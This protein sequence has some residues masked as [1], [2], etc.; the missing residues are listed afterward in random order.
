MGEFNRGKKFGGWKGG[1]KFG[2]RQFGGNRGGNRRFS[3]GRDGGRT[4]M[5]RAVCSNCGINCEVPFRP[6]GDKPVFCN[7]CFKKMGNRGDDSQRNFRDGRNREFGERKSGAFFD[8]K[9]PYQSGGRN[10]S[11]NYKAQFEILNSKLDKILKALTPAVSAQINKDEEP[12]TKKFDKPLKKEVDT[13]SLRK[14][15]TETMDKKHTAKENAAGKKAA[16]KK[17]KK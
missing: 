6:T 16:V 11:Q 15:L 2:K 14:A 3:G 5:H 1:N 13:N 7:D 8:D 17:K 12:K 9:R 4:E 10:D